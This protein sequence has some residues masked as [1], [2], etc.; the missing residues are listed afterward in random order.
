MPAPA[1]HHPSG[2]LGIN[3]WAQ[4]ARLLRMAAAVFLVLTKS[5]RMRRRI[6]T[7]NRSSRFDF[8]PTR[9]S[10]E[11]AFRWCYRDVCLTGSEIKHVYDRASDVFLP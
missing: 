2:Q 1:G 7:A 8:D 6:V 5:G 3:A 10:H 11:R 4:A 9:Q